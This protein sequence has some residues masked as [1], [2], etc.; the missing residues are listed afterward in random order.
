MQNNYQPNFESGIKINNLAASAYFSNDELHF[1]GW[2]VPC[3][4][5]DGYNFA[6]FNK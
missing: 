5:V 3:F 6:V 2:V 1:F 4:L